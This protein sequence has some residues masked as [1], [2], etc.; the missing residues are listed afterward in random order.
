[1]KFYRSI[2]FKISFP[3]AIILSLF[4]YFLLYNKNFSEGFLKTFSYAE[5][6]TIIFIASFF[7]CW[8]LVSFFVLRKLKIFSEIVDKRAKNDKS[9]FVKLDGRDEI[10]NLSCNFNQMLESTD[11]LQYFLEERDKEISLSN[12][13]IKLGL[14]A[15]GDAIWDWDL[16]TDQIWFSPNVKKMLGYTNEELEDSF[17]VFKKIISADNYELFL[18]EI[19]KSKI[20]AV[21]LD[22]IFK[23]NHKYSGVKYIRIG[24]KIVS[25][26]KE[27]IRIIGAHS[28]VTELKRAEENLKL[29]NISLEAKQEELTKAMKK[30]EISANQKTEFLANM[31]HEIRTPMNGIIGMVSLLKKTKLTNEQQQFLKTIDNSSEALLEIV[32]DILD[33]SKIEAGKVDIEHV[34]FDL[35]SLIEDLIDIVIMKTRDKKIDIFYNIEADVERFLIGD[36]AKIKQILLN[37]TSNAIKFTESGNIQISV[38]LDNNLTDDQA[39]K[40]SQD[41]IFSV[42]DTGIGIPKNKQSIIFKKFDQADNSTTRRFG[43][44]GLGLAICKNLT[45]MMDGKIWV[46]SEEGEGSNF[47]FSLHLEKDGD[48]E[49]YDYRIRNLYNFD[50]ILIICDEACLSQS[51][52]SKAEIWGVSNSVLGFREFE[53]K[54]TDSLKDKILI[55]A[56]SINEEPKYTKFIY[57]HQFH[58]SNLL[59]FISS[60]ADNKV[61]R[62][63][64]SDYKFNLYFQHPINFDKL[65][66]DIESQVK[67]KAIGVEMNN[68]TTDIKKFMKELMTDDPSLKTDKG[69]L[70]SK[71]LEKYDKSSDEQI[72]HSDKNILVV[73][74]NK[75]NQ[76]VISKMLEKLNVKVDI[77]SDGLE[78]LEKF[79]NSDIKYHLIFMDCQMPNLDGYETTKK[80]REYE[81][82]KSRVNKSS[83]PIIA[84]TANAIKGDDD[85]CFK[86]GMDDYVAK[87]VDLN[88]I[89]T[90]LEYWL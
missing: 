75:V 14:E 20:A 86:A 3:L 27:P 85:K 48:K 54:P 58:D 8:S 84:L 88:V 28:D 11:Q 56:P 9:A 89:K 87:P 43:G 50:E 47:L 23:F 83:I 30:V 65:R 38:C 76:L 41:L 17:E 36:K 35:Y 70:K 21:E 7:L 31:S 64:I 25:D 67:S 72:E 52:S 82:T 49:K 63:L 5:I 12:S 45:E 44:T 24:T 71:G 60:L 62:K 10:Y 59:C 73:E 80:I 79:K 4:L 1:M 18:K 61:K 53:N 51:L 69:K 55:F 19:E 74:D 66:N 26:S 32:N 39:S 57:K 22:K 46:E 42:K 68:E 90:K 34:P 6:A 16:K 33:F 2:N 29:Y 78:G 13:L 77:A 15:S 81:K 37:L 40:K